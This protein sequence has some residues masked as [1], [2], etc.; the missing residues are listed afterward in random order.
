[1][2]DDKTLGGILGMAGA[3]LARRQLRGLIEVKP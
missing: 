3:I 1:L 2:E